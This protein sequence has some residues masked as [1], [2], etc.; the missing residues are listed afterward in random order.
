MRPV[1]HA[2]IVVLVTLLVGAALWSAEP[3]V[4]FIQITDTHVVDLAEVHPAL[5]K[6]REHFA[7]TGAALDHFLTSVAPSLG[8]R[9]RSRCGPIRATRSRCAW[10]TAASALS[11]KPRRRHGARAI[12]SGFKAT[13]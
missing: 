13:V 2:L 10:T 8:I 3:A 12:A 7:K 1:R 6:S 5:A 11:P 4:D 9:S